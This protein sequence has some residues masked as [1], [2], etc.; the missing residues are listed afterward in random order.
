MTASAS[1]SR[2]TLSRRRFLAVSVALAPVAVGVAGTP[3]S[4]PALAASDPLEWS[5]I[6]DRLFVNYDAAVKAL[7]LED[8]ETFIR[9]AD[10]HWPGVRDA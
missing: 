9:Q 2:P 5:I 8:P 4:A 1:R 3:R 10:G 7:W 6:G